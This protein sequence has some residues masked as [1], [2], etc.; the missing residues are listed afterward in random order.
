[1]LCIF[2]T[3]GEY[4]SYATCMATSLVALALAYSL[5]RWRQIA[6]FTA[7]F[8]E[9]H[10]TSRLWKSSGTLWNFIT[11]MMNGTTVSNGY[12]L[13]YSFFSVTFEHF[14]RGVQV[15]LLD[16]FFEN[17]CHTRAPQRRVHD[18]A[19]YKSTFASLWCRTWHDFQCYIVVPL[20]P[21]QASWI[22]TEGTRRG[23]WSSQWQRFS[24][25]SL[26]S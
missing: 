23:W 22:S 15:K 4:A 11:R 3:G 7:N 16:P 17:A 24:G 14:T 8:M 12:K 9:F 13:L 21:C 1:M 18:E 20:S 2:L 10:V 26:V 25:C 19:L 6:T 5:A